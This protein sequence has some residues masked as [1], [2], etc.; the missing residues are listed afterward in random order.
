LKPALPRALKVG[1]PHRQMEQA[2]AAEGAQVTASSVAAT[3][4]ATRARTVRTKAKLLF[5]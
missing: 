4:P 5:E 3:I 1:S 2:S